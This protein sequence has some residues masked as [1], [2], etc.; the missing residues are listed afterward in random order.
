MS[1]Q[2]ER[3]DAA[4]MRIEWLGGVSVG[5][6]CVEEIKLM[7]RLEFSVAGGILVIHERTWLGMISDFPYCRRIRVKR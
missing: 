3:R 7:N 5:Q 2:I 1:V 6:P 4:R